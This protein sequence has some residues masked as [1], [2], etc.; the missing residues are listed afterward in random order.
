MAGLRGFLVAYQKFRIINFV[1]IILGVFTFLAPLLC[2]IFTDSLFWIVF[3]LMIM[4]LFVWFIY[5][6]QC[7][8]INANLKNQ[9]KIDFKVIRP[10]LKLSGWMSISNITA[11]FIL[12]ADRFLIGIIISAAALTYYVVP[13][14]IITKLLLIPSA[15]VMVLFPAFSTSFV[16][17]PELSKKLLLWGIKSIFL[18]LYPIIFL[19]ITFAFEGI[20]IWLGEQFANKSTFILQ[21]LAAGVFFNSIAHVTFTFIQGIGRPDLTGKLNIVE[22]PIYFLSMW[23]AIKAWGINGA[24]LVWFL[25][26]FIDNIMLF[27]ISGKLVSRFIDLKVVILC[28]IMTTMFIISAALFNVYLKIT[29]TLV[30]F[31]MF[32]LISWRFILEDTEK[33]LILSKLNVTNATKS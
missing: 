15:I 24:A 21:M 13:F 25:R 23:I 8:K 31:L 28:L 32:F 10:I 2:L 18:F 29:F 27:L 1:R 12:Y 17:K 22:I 7:L 11:P 6:G 3:S 16:I 5:L 19:V 14:E 26:A 33:S 4:R 9:I 20:S 30:V